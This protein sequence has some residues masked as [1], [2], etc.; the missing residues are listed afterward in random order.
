[1]WPFS[2]PPKPQPRFLVKNVLGE[3]IDELP[4]QDLAGQCLCG[5]QWPHA[6]LSGLSLDG[7]DCSGINLFGA[8]LV[9]TSF[10]RCSLVGAELSFSDAT[11]ADFSQANMDGCLLY[12]AETRGANFDQT[13]ISPASDIPGMRVVIA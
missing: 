9:R 6:D 7:A 12:R 1:M 8:R 11:G 2:A 4:V 10:C 3:I 5:K 13:I